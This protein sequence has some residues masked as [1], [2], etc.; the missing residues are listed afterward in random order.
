MS[1]YIEHADRR[2]AD[3]QRALTAEP[4][5]AE[6]LALR[7][8]GGDAH[9]RQWRGRERK[10]SLIASFEAAEEQGDA[11]WRIARGDGAPGRS[12]GFGEIPRDEGLA[13]LIAAAA[14]GWT[15]NGAVSGEAQYRARAAVC[16]ALWRK[17]R[18]PPPVGDQAARRRRLRQG[19]HGLRLL[20]QAA[21]DRRRP[22]DPAGYRSRP[23][24]AARRHGRFR[25]RRARLP[26]LQ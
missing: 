11:G 6:R 4:A 5:S 9:R 21:A 15:A 22:S 18:L 13:A 14:C 20:R 7:T 23:R 24:P 25:E 16:A 3:I 1:C 19:T 2:V 12:A 10:R 8:L 26:R 17:Q